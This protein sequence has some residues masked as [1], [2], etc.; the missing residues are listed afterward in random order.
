MTFC[1]SLNL[2]LTDLYCEFH[3]E[4]Q[5]M[6]MSAL[7]LV[8]I[9]IIWVA[10]NRPW[11]RAPR[12]C[13]VSRC[14]NTYL[15]AHRMYMNYRCYQLIQQ[16][17]IFTQIRAVGIVDWIFIV[18]A[19]YWLWLGEHLTLGRTFYSLLFEQEVVTATQLTDLLR[20]LN[21]C[22][23]R[24][25]VT[26]SELLF[27]GSASGTEQFL[28]SCSGRYQFCSALDVCVPGHNTGQ[29]IGVTMLTFRNLASHT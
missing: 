21:I 22:S 13:L 8:A 7:N 15:A 4:W 10:S 3:D 26:L 24:L 16:R 12:R 28:C 25:A 19:P 14:T 1:P 20:T 29:K 11:L 18:G 5:W 9:L 17:N 6:K 23:V 27:S 2:P